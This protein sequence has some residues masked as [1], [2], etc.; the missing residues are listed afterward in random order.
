MRIQYYIAPE[1]EI[2]EVLVEVR[3]LDGSVGTVTGPP[4]VGGW[5]GSEE[6]W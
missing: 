3:F 5:G 1:A 4:D 6:D 2:I